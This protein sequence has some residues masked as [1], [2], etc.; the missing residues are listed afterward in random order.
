MKSR[1]AGKFRTYHD[2]VEATPVL[3]GYIEVE[4]PKGMIMGSAMTQHE[5]NAFALLES[6]LNKES[7]NKVLEY[8]GST[9]VCWIGFNEKYDLDYHISETPYCC[10]YGRKLFPEISFYD[11]VPELDNVDIFYVRSS[12]Q[13]AQDWKGVLTQVIDNNHPSKI[14]LDGTNISPKE[15]YYTVQYAG[16]TIDSAQYVKLS[17]EDRVRISPSLETLI[18]QSAN[19]QSPPDDVRFSFHKVMSYCVIG[20]EE[21]TSF[22]DGRGYKQ[23]YQKS[24]NG[25]VP[26]TDYVYETI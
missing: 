26:S 13:Y 11:H 8:G 14:I 3:T 21:L 17:S 10:E 2:L 9:G 19:L 24:N 6:N 22:L 18:P 5:K 20:G 4:N 15:T 23:I 16:V 12:L 25:I 7:S 1:W